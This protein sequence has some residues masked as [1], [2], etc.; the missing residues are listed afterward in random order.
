MAKDTE[1][2]ISQ[3]VRIENKKAWHDYHIVE[4]IETGIVLAGTEVKSL[5]DKQASLDGSY[6]RITDGECWLINANIA[7]YPKAAYGNHDPL[8]ERKLLLHRRQIEK[9]LSKLKQRG[10]T[11]IPLKIYFSERGLAKVE[12]GIATGKRQYDKR[13][14]LKG[15]EAKKELARNNRRR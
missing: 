2:N 13:A 1:K 4:K 15:K 3:Q 11:L 8:R 9:L 6:A 7:Q 10:F 14:A 12:L 5:R